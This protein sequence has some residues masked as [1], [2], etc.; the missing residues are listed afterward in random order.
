MTLVS[1]AA[2]NLISS[3]AHSFLLVHIH[4]PL[5]FN[6]LTEPGRGFWIS[7]AALHSAE[8]VCATA[9][10][11]LIHA[12]INKQIHACNQS[13]NLFIACPAMLRQCACCCSCQYLRWRRSYFCSWD[14]SLEGP[15][16]PQFHCKRWEQTSQE[17]FQVQLQSQSQRPA[18]SDAESLP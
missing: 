9:T 18:F 4:V 17:A 8:F 3:A 12:L 11:C 7:H 1:P 2:A 10:F 14:Q 13:M 6:R 5:I 15:S 16:N